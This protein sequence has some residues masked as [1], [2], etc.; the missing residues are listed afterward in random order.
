MTAAVRAL[1]VCRPTGDAHV[2]VWLGRRARANG[3]RT[4]ARPA[5]RGRGAHELPLTALG[6]LAQW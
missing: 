5:S 1:Y 6:A 4:G 3:S 2:R